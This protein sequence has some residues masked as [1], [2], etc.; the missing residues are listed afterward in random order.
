MTE[1]ARRWLLPAD[2]RLLLAERRAVPALHQ[3]ADDAHGLIGARLR[4]GRL[5]G[6]A[7]TQTSASIRPASR[8]SGLADPS[9]KPRKLRALSSRPSGLG[10]RM[11]TDPSCFQRMTRRSGNVLMMSRSAWIVASGVLAQIWIDRSPWHSAGSSASLGNRAMRWRQRGRSGWSH[12]RSSKKLCPSD[13]SSSGCRARS[14][15]RGCRN[16]PAEAWGRVRA[17]GRPP[18]GSGSAR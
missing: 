17:P 5:V 7:P 16:R 10:G 15:G 11:G 3:I 2:D 4:P 14:R 12:G 6:S 1:G 8:E 13:R 18:S 9:R